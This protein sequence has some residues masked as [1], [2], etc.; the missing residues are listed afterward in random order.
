M[1]PTR[2][3]FHFETRS[4]RAYKRIRKHYRC[5]NDNSID[6]KNA[7]CFGREAITLSAN[8]SKG[9]Q[10]NENPDLVNSPSP[11]TK[12]SIECNTDG[13]EKSKLSAEDYR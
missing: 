10:Q 6:N 13:T 1:E 5:H 9:H 3:A 11:A 4:F 7:C 12:P 8:A 2:L